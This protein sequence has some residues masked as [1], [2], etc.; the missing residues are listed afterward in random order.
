MF[1]YLWAGFKKENQIER[2]HPTEKPKEL[3]KWT[4]RHYAEIGE[5]ILDTNGGSFSHAIAAYRAGI[6]SASS[7][8][9][10][11][12]ALTHAGQRLQRA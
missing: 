6:L 3:Y 9:L 8:K 4:L 12:G 10:L 11:G 1:S 2:I 7:P 5:S